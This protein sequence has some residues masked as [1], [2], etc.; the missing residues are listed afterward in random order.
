MM[1]EMRRWR[2]AAL[3]LPEL[4]L[5]GLILAA[6]AWVVN[7]V[8]VDGYL[9]QPFLFDTRDTFMDWFNTAYWAHNGGAYSVWR[10]VY[11]PLS[12]AF[13]KLFGMPSCYG[14]DALYGGRS[15]DVLGQVSLFAFYFLGMALAFAALHRNDPRTGWLRGL[16]LCFSYPALFVLERGNL[17]VPCF[18]FFV[19]AYGNLLRNGWSRALAMAITINFKPYLLVPAAALA[20]PRNWRMLEIALIATV[21]VYFASYGIVGEGSPIEMIDNTFNWVEVTTGASLGDVYQTTTLNTF[22]DAIDQG[23]RI[24]QFIDS[25][26]LEFWMDIMRISMLI[27][28]SLAVASLVGAWLQ[29][30]A[31]TANRAA[32]LLF[33]LALTI[34]SPGGYTEIFV[35]FLLFLE[36]WKRP[37]QIVA[38]IAGYLIA[39]PY[40]VVFAQVLNRYLDS[41][42]TGR[43]VVGYFGV[44]YGIFLRP[45]LLLL[46][47]A[48]LSYDT[49]SQTIK[50]HRR[51]R[52]L[53]W[54]T[55]RTT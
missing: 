13:L 17:I 4:L 53:L 7:T 20:I 30:Q 50:A 29:P 16:A 55:P 52:P 14:A 25:G 15:C 47:L 8:I 31:L 44:S 41:W 27:V 32:L 28:Q 36:P 21:G 24:L 22:F 6:V 23:F 42:L 18:V 37:G 45:A 19:L 1:A 12:F 5:L 39:V 48:G 38:L 49:L 33:T 51:D 54:L 3:I 46:M 10:T 9:P 11:P 34:R 35:L 26:G 43:A 40:D 2:A